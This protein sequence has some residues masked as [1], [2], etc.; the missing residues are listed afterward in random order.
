MGATRTLR[1]IQ[2]EPTQLIITA[3]E[4]L[5]RE[6][7][8]EATL[9]DVV[10]EATRINQPLAVKVFF[11]RNRRDD[12]LTSDGDINEPALND[13]TVYKTGIHFQYKYQLYHLG[14][15][16]TGGTDAKD[17]VLDNE[18]QLEQVV[19]SSG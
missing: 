3:L 14:I 12:V 16:T 5:H 10:I 1:C 8:R 17:V 15:L 2:Y 7:V 19:S 13:P 11:T 4:R 18:W 9:A 6:G